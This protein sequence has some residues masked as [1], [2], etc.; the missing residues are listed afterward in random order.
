MWLLVMSS[1][2]ADDR[3]ELVV[4]ELGG[5]ARFTHRGEQ[6]QAQ[7]FAFDMLKTF[8]SGSCVSAGGIVLLRRP[9]MKWYCWDKNSIIQLEEIS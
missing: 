4:M 6:F 2:L 8:E 3:S 7:L 1:A 5:M 9:E